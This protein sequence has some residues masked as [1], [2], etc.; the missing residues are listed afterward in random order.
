MNSGLNLIAAQQLQILQDSDHLS[1]NEVDL[2]ESTLTPRDNIQ[3]ES[4]GLSVYLDRARSDQDRVAR[5]F[6]NESHDSH[7]SGNPS[8]A[9]KLIDYLEVKDDLLQIENEDQSHFY[10]KKPSKLKRELPQIGVDILKEFIHELMTSRQYDTSG[11]S[12]EK[13]FF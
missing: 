13:Y 3:F 6:S 4:R 11:L 9:L 12:L 10:R 5:G 1:S 7:D 2:S 8:N